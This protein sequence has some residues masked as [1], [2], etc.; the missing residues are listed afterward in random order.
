MPNPTMLPTVG[1]II[2][3]QITPINTVGLNLL[4]IPPPPLCHFGA[5]KSMYLWG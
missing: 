5:F 2:D 1:W 4:A 3:T